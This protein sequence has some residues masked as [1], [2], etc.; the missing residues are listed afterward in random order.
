[1][2]RS[3][4]ASSFEPPLSSNL[5]TLPRSQAGSGPT[6]AQ[7]W[8]AWVDHLERRHF[9][10]MLPLTVSVAL[11]C[12]FATI[13]DT[14]QMVILLLAVSLL[15]LPHGSLDYLSGHSV[16]RPF[17]GRLWPVPFGFSYLGL[18]GL[19]VSGWLLA[20]ALSLIVFLVLAAGHFGIGD[21]QSELALG[22]NT[23]FAHFGVALEA[24]ARGALVIVVLIH[25]HPE[26]ASRLFAH[27]IPTSADAVYATV[28]T[29]SPRLAVVSGA[30][31]AVVM[32]HH[33]GGWAEGVPEHG[34]IALEIAA[35]TALF[36][37]APP[38]IAFVVYFCCWHSFRH[39]MGQA[40]ELDASSAKAG[41]LALL[42]HA[43]PATL[44]AI[45]MG[46][47]GYVLLGAQ[48]SREGVLWI[49][50]V[51]LSALTVPH[52]LFSWLVHRAPEYR[53]EIRRPRTPL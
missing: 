44:G 39:S 16:F 25:M 15:G 13:P 6:F 4:T 53:G 19:V 12:L 5:A 46:A 11:G 32:A 49:V 42:R 7:N 1:M 10:V 51:G 20:P 27:L 18:M 48:T 28:V 34:R 17:F 35:L 29:V 26:A 9:Q 52:V 21:V 31:L 45:L 3:A 40:A 14:V 43:W 8:P 30:M 41:F 38:L 47:A 24:A 33:L 22:A 23:R 37:L 50:F 36:C 2:A